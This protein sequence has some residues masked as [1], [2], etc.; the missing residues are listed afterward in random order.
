MENKLVNNLNQISDLNSLFT[1]VDN[2][3]AKDIGLLGGRKFKHKSGI[4]GEIALNDIVRKF[5]GLRN[6]IPQNEN[7]ALE[8]RRKI[9]QLDDAA[10]QKLKKTNY[11]TQILTALR[12]IFGSSPKQQTKVTDF[13]T[14]TRNRVLRELAASFQANSAYKHTYLGEE[15]FDDT[16][17]GIEKE[18]NGVRSDSLEHTIIQWVEQHIGEAEDEKLIKAQE[19]NLLKSVL[20]FLQRSSSD[21]SL[22]RKDEAFL[23]RLVYEY[24]QSEDQLLR[25]ELAVLLI[26]AYANAKGFLES[27]FSSP[28]HPMSHFKVDIATEESWEPKKDD[29]DLLSRAAEKYR[30]IIL[31][32]KGKAA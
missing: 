24:R 11:F 23:K 25:T 26:A 13:F 16:S 7:V 10:D 3:E 21:S 12:S 1:F 28:K 8:I 4:N 14:P 9:H 32:T 30:S 31:E 18:I 5:D 27:D 15:I 17:H 19:Q 6:Q 29:P 2:L 22:A 20:E